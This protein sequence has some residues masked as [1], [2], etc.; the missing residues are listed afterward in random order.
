MLTAANPLVCVCVQADARQLGSTGVASRLLPAE[1]RRYA[2]VTGKVTVPLDGGSM[3]HF[4]SHVDSEEA[5]KQVGR[6][7]C[8]GKQLW[9]G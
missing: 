9:S 5:R 2:G 8:G 7:C 6:C 3:H 4:L 1:W